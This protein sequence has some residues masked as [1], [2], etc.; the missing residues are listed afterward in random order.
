MHTW[1][2][3]LLFKKTV[4]NSVLGTNCVYQMILQQCITKSN[5]LFHGFVVRYVLSMPI[6][7]CATIHLKVKTVSNLELF[8]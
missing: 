7:Y 2:K 8:G 1:H 3:E 6:M 4:F 5:T